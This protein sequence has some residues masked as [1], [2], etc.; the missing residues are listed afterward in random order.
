MA[1]ISVTAL[2]V[3]LITFGIWNDDEYCQ[4]N[5]G[6]GPNMR[7]DRYCYEVL[8]ESSTWEAVMGKIG[9]WLIFGSIVGFLVALW[10]FFRH[11]LRKR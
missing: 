3:G 11:H 10:W 9:G 1:W 5:P 2:V 4:R 7:V 8:A 6:S